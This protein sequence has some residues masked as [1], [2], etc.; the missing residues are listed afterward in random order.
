M[1]NRL[2]LPALSFSLVVVFWT[3][4]SFVQSSRPQLVTRPIPVESGFLSATKYTNAFFGFSLPLPKSSD[5][6]ELSAPPKGPAL[7]DFLLG[8]ASNNGM[9]TFIVTAKKAGIVSDNPARN[10]AAG[11]MLLKTREMQIGGQVF[12]RSDS[13]Q[14]KREGEL[15]TLIFATELKKYVVTFY[16]ASFDSKLTAELEHS[17]EGLTF[18]DSAKAQDEAGAESKPYNPSLPQITNRIS[19]LSD[20]AISASTYYNSDLGFRYQ[21]PDGWTPYDKSMQADM[22]DAGHQFVWRGPFTER[23]HA[24]GNECTKNLLFLTRYPEG[25]RLNRF[26]PVVLV[27]AMDPKCSPEVT[28]PASVKDRDAVQHIA[29]LFVNSFKTARMTSLGS[30]RVRAFD[31]AGRVMLEISQSSSLVTSAPGSTVTYNIRTSL[32]L[33]QAGEYW[34]MWFFATDDDAELEQLRKTKIVFNTAPTPATDAR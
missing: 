9:N 34:V 10:D 8:F 31:N 11:P 32:L 14:K 21:F 19:Q 5:L 30:V 6:R 33:M 18:F 13:H 17:I 28:F 25:M 27:M 23:E 26:N 24:P 20:G 15:Q 2:R 16:I 22:A 29:S 7:S 12:W 1:R 4:A 3:A